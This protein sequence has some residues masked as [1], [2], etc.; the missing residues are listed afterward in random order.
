[1]TH[2]RWLVLPVFTREWR[3]FFLKSTQYNKNPPPITQQTNP[4]KKKPQLLV[5]I[6]VH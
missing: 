6:H 1:M 3:S 2:V 4:K 5:K